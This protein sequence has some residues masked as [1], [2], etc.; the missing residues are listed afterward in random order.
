METDQISVVGVDVSKASFD[1]YLLDEKG[2]KQ[3]LKLKNEQEGFYKLLASLPKEGNVKVVMEASGPYYYQL[4][5]FLHEQAVDVVVENPLVIKRFSQMKLQRT[6]TDKADAMVIWQ[7]GSLMQTKLWQPLKENYLKIKQLY[8][9][10]ELLEKYKHGTARQ[11]E[12]FMAT[13]RLAECLEM[14]MQQDLKQLEEKIKAIDK[15]LVELIK[16]ENAE[17]KK[18]L[19]SIPGIGPKASLLLI[20]SLRGFEDFQNYKQVISYLG[21]SPRIFESGTSV[22]GKAKICKMGMGKVRACL[23]MAALSAK[24]HNKACREIYGRLRARGKAH[25][26]AMIAVVNK[27]LKQA[28][29]LVQSGQMYNPDHLIKNLNTK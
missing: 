13:G 8:A 24:K 6:K 15:Q 3:T 19:E 5:C 7:Y 1:A 17:L 22:K 2:K 27:L 11:L 9:R 21:L 25:R 14:Q 26:Q 29:A 4:A 23:Y 10:R 16:Q 28:F 18:Q 12:A 20:V